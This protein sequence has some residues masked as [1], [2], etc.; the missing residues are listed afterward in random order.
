MIQHICP[1]PVNMEI[2]TFPCNVK[3]LTGVS[4]LSHSWWVFL[5]FLQSSFPGKRLW[6]SLWVT[7]LLGVKNADSAD[8]RSF[9]CLQ[10]YY[11]FGQNLALGGW[12]EIRGPDLLLRELLYDFVY[13]SISCVPPILNAGYVSNA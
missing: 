7:A 5:G 12:T 4:V 6:S 10:F 1:I 8:L 11:G 2:L 13:L 3:V 9:P